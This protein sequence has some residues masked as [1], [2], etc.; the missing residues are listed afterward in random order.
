[1]AG[2]DPTLCF[3]GG[4]GTVTGSKNLVRA[5]GESILL[6]CGLFQGLKQLRLRNWDAPPFDPRSL[7]A[8]V[9][10]HA[11]LDHVGYLPVLVRRGF[12]G[13]VFCTPATASLAAVV[14]R[15]A[16]HLQEE[17]AERANRRGYTRHRPAL[18]LF[19]TDDAEQALA[20]LRPRGYG[21]AFAAARAAQV[22]FRRAGHILGSATIELDLE[23]PR[24][25]RVCF[26]G[27]LGRPGRPILRDPEPIGRADV[28]L[29]ESTYG[30]RTH[31]A[32][33]ADELARV[34]G[35]TARRGGALIVPAFAIDRAQELLWMLHA[36]EEAGRLPLVSVHLDSPMAI[37]VTDIYCQHP[38][39]HD[40]EMQ[41]LMDLERCPLRSREL[42]RART[43]LESKALLERQGPLIIIA[44]SGMATGGRVLHHLAHRLP[45]HRSTVLFTGFQAVGTRG[46]A[47]L[48]G[49][50]SVRI[51]GRDVPVRAHI[52]RI[53]GLSAHA[54][55]AEA[56]R[57]LGGFERPPAMTWLV[58]GEAAQ[59]E[60]LRDALRGRLG[61]TAEVAADGAT[62]PLEA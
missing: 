57:W 8:V 1:M 49:A 39:E 45:D 38:E 27:D 58:H 16:A 40:L 61:W 52:E 46:R 60:G 28:L 32:G 48:D 13:P 36:L 34:I 19:T 59:A 10:S 5:G 42:H 18:P 14:L 43:T 56:L 51:H 55:Q 11:H 2:H 6:D 7:A 3:A 15:D 9:L 41:T 12:R 4:A 37:D 17:D 35:E 30:D 44:G 62:V 50:R 22:T 24:P 29:L 53:D 33:P 54:D 25:L 26:T 21:E 20:L 31:A 23:E 47:L